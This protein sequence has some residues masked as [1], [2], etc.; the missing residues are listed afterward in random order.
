MERIK[1]NSAIPIISEVIPNVIINRF[2]YISIAGTLFDPATATVTLNGQSCEI[3][4]IT[5]TAI[6]CNASP[7]DYYGD[8]S[9]AVQ[10]RGFTSSP[11]VI[12][13]TPMPPTYD[14]IYPNYIVTSAS[15]QVTI[16]GSQF[17]IGLT[18]ATIGGLPCSSPSVLNNG[19]TIWCYSPAINTPGIQQVVI[20][21]G[22]AD[23]AQSSN[24]VTIFAP[25]TITRVNPSTVV[26]Q[27]AFFSITGTGFD[28][29]TIVNV[30][31]QAATTTKLNSTFIECNVPPTSYFGNAPLQVFTRDIG[32]N[33]ATLVMT[34]IPAVITSVY[35][36]SI[37][38][39][40]TPIVTISGSNFV[41]GSG[42][43]ITVGSL[44]CNGYNVINSTTVLCYAPLRNVVGSQ[45]IVI[46]I[47]NVNSNQFP[48]NY[49]ATAPPPLIF[50][51]LPELVSTS[52]PIITIYGQYFALSYTVM[53]NNQPC[54][55]SQSPTS[56]MIICEATQLRN[57]NFNS[58]TQLQVK[59]NGQFSNAV[60][61]RFVTNPP[62]VISIYP[63]AIQV[64]TSP[65]IT[66][67]GNQFVTGLSQVTIGGRPCPTV[68]NSGHT[69]TCQVPPS[70]ASSLPVLVINGALSSTANANTIFVNAIGLTGTGH[71]LFIGDTPCLTGNAN[72]LMMSAT[73][74]IVSNYGQLPLNIR[75]STGVTN[76][77]MVTVNYPQMQPIVSSVTP[78]VY[79]MGETT[80]VTLTGNF[81]VNPRVRVLQTS[82][83]FP[84][85]TYVS[86]SILTF[87]VPP[88]FFQNE[89]S[90]Q[91][92]VQTPTSSSNGAFFNVGSP[93]PS[94][95]S[96]N[97]QSALNNQSTLI[98]IS[99]VGFVD[100]F[101]RVTINNVQV[102]MTVASK[103]L[104]FGFVNPPNPA[105][106]GANQ[107]L[108][109]NGQRTG[110]PS[111]IVYKP[112]Q[113]NITSLS[114]S[115]KLASDTTNIVINGYGFVAGLMT[116]MVGNSQ[117]QSNTVS[118]TSIVFSARPENFVGAKQITVMHAG[119]VSNP[120][121][122]TYTGITPSID[123]ISSQSVTNIQSTQVTITGSNFMVGYISVLIQFD[124]GPVNCTILDSTN[125]SIIFDSPEVAEAGQKTVQVLNGNTVNTGSFSIL[126]Q[127]PGL[128][129]DSI[130]PPA[131]INTHSTV[132]TIH[133][134]GFDARLLTVV[135]NFNF[136]CAM[137]S[138]D[139]HYT[140]M[141]VLTSFSYTFMSPQPVV[142]S[143]Y[144]N[145]V[146]IDGSLPVTLTGSNF[147]KG[148]SSVTTGE[149]VFDS[150]PLP[151][152]GDFPCRVYNTRDNLFAQ[153]TVKYMPLPS[154][155]SITP[156]SAYA[157]SG[158]VFTIVGHGF[159]AAYSI[160][161]IM[162]PDHIEYYIAHQV[163]PAGANGLVQTYVTLPK[164]YNCWNKVTITGS[165]FMVGYVSVLIQSASGPVNC[166]IVELTST[167]IIFNSPEVAE[168]GQKTVQV[169]N[170]NTANSGS[171][172]ILYQS[173]ELVVDSIDPPAMI[174]T[175]STVITIHGSGFDARILSVVDNFNFRCAM[176]SSDVHYT[177][178]VCNLQPPPNN[179]VGTVTVT[180]KSLTDSVTSFS[181]TFMSPQPVVNSVYPNPVNIDG[182]LPV[183]LTGSN[184]QKGVTTV[185]TGGITANIIS[186]SPTEIV[187]DSTPL[188][189]IGDFPCRVYNTRDNL[190]AQITVKY[191]PLPSI[192]SI[193]PTSAN[194][195]SGTVFTIVGH[196]F[197]AAYS[198]IAIMAPDHIEY[199]IAHQVDPAGANGLVQ[200]YVTLPNTITAGTKYMAINNGPLSTQN[201]LPVEIVAPVPTIS[202]VNPSTVVNIQSTLIVIT[203]TNFDQSTTVSII[204]QVKGSVP[205]PVDTYTATTISCIAPQLEEF[206]SKQLVVAN[207]YGNVYGTINYES[208]PIVIDR[209]LPSSMPN[210]IATTITIKGSGFDTRITSFLPDPN[211]NCVVVA[212]MRDQYICTVQPPPDQ[213]EGDITVTI[214][215]L[216]PGDSA[217][218]TFTYLNSMPYLSAVQPYVANTDGSIPVTVIGSGFFDGVTTVS[219]P[220]A[221]P[222]QTIVQSITLNEIVFTI[223]TNPEISAGGHEVKVINGNNPLLAIYFYVTYLPTPQLLAVD[224]NFQYLHILVPF[225]LYGSGFLREFTTVYITDVNNPSLEQTVFGDDINPDG[226][227]SFRLSDQLMVP[228]NK[229][230]YVRNGPSFESQRLMVEVQ[231]P[232][233]SIDRIEP[234]AV[235]NQNV[236]QITLTGTNFYGPTV[237]VRISMF[238][239]YDCPVIENI[240]YD[241]LIINSPNVQNNVGTYMIEITVFDNIGRYPIEFMSSTIAVDS[242]VPSSMITTHATTITILG[243][244]FDSR[245]LSV[246]DNFNFRCPIPDSNVQFNSIVCTVQPTMYAYIGDVRVTL[247][248]STGTSATFLF[249]F[250]SPQPNITSVSPMI[251]NTAGSTLITISGSS[252]QEGISS[253]L[254]NGEIE[255]AIS[256]ITPNQI[257]FTSN[258]VPEGIQNITVTNSGDNLSATTQLLYLPS[259]VL[260][261][262]T[263]TFITNEVSSIITV[264]GTGFF[265]GH[266]VI[267]VGSPNEIPDLTFTVDNI[268]N[269]VD[270]I[271]SIP[272]LSPFFGVKDI[273]AY[274]GPS[275]SNIINLQVYKPTPV[276][277]NVDPQ[278]VDSTTATNVTLTGTN[279]VVDET[280]LSISPNNDVFIPLISIST[281]EIIFTTNVTRLIGIR[282]IFLQVEGAQLVSKDLEFLPGVPVIT[283][284][285][286]KSMNYSAQTTFTLTGYN[287]YD[288]STVSGCIVLEQN[289]TT[290]TCL[291]F[292]FFDGMILQNNTYKLRVTNNNFDSN[293]VSVQV[294]PITPV[295][296][297]ISPSVLYS[298]Q[299]IS[300]LVLTSGVMFG[301]NVTINDIQVRIFEINL[302]RVY[303]L[304]PSLPKG[305]YPLVI[306]N[307]PD[308]IAAYALTF[309]DPTPI[310]TGVSPNVTDLYATNTIITISG[311][312]FVSNFSIIT[313]G[314][315]QCQNDSTVTSTEI[316]CILSNVTTQGVLPI[317]IQNGDIISNTE[318]VEFMYPLPVNYVSPNYVIFSDQSTSTFTITLFGHGFSHY[319]DG[320]VQ[321]QKEVVGTTPTLTYQCNVTTKTDTSIECI[322]SMIPIGRYEVLFYSGHLHS[323]TTVFTVVDRALSCLSTQG[324]S[325]SWWFVR[326]IPQ[327]QSY[328][329]VDSDSQ[330]MKYLP[331]INST[332]G[333]LARTLNQIAISSS[334][335]S[336]GYVVYNDHPWFDDLSG[337]LSLSIN[338][339][340]NLNKSLGKGIFVANTFFNATYSPGF[341]IKHSMEGFPVPLPNGLFKTPS[342][343]PSSWIP[344]DYHLIQNQGDDYSLGHS[345]MC[346]SLIDSSDFVNGIQSLKPF[347][348]SSNRFTPTSTTNIF[349]SLFTDSTTN[350]FTSK[351]WSKGYFISAGFRNDIF[352][353]TRIQPL[354]ITLPS[355]FKIPSGANAITDVKLPTEFIIQNNIPTK[356]SQ[357][358]SDI[359]KSYI[360]FNDTHLCLGDYSSKTS[361]GGGIAVCVINQF[362][363][364]F[365]VES[366]FKY[367]Q[368]N[369]STPKCENQI[370]NQFFISIKS[371]LLLDNTYSSNNNDLQMILNNIDSILPNT[372]LS[373]GD[374]GCFGIFCPI[375]APYSEIKVNPTDSVGIFSFR[376]SYTPVFNLILQDTNSSITVKSNGSPISYST[377]NISGSFTAKT[378]GNIQSNNVI[379]AY[380]LIQIVKKVRDNLG[381]GT[382]G[383]IELILNGNG[384]AILNQHNDIP[385]KID[386]N[387]L[388]VQSLFRAISYDLILQLN[389]ATSSVELPELN[390]DSYL[391]FQNHQ[392]CWEE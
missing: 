350:S 39:D 3:T 72:V 17:E 74:T 294:L 63:S 80:Q 38:V 367:Q 2:P 236:T 291:T 265:V 309:I 32:S 254:I 26:N 93:L 300:L 110:S 334:E 388:D 234:A 208:P 299:Q 11:Y 391:N 329:Y 273:I 371:K 366:I 227:I 318:Y 130:D 247:R 10:S 231:W 85:V 364:E 304:T 183:T 205:C 281:T 34:P 264:T 98:Q 84:Q 83:E 239:V 282:S 58:I 317:N 5:S 360:A 295:I 182:S 28:G 108:V 71:R 53:V 8:A 194:L 351:D 82:M 44:S 115:S 170:G 314:A 45:P 16:S 344:N 347:I 246:D 238:E 252:F 189:S 293:E 223:S 203:G 262:I 268:E 62:N 154:I 91:L 370:Q 118:G 111:Q 201:P 336:N 176:L 54:P 113:P 271:I 139:V 42:S 331:S 392:H 357:W 286:P 158:T 330:D 131:M 279:F 250:S 153:I 369:C 102:Q 75:T 308:Q 13:M 29:S 23:S 184:F 50:S 315:Y 56:T 60:Q 140:Y 188:P 125:T 311:S 361:F 27:Y 70:A 202:S 245:L 4:S 192:T 40:T 187:F 297:S 316:Q 141:T 333:C 196:G 307:S 335:S 378:N 134:S 88:N 175:H 198:I 89:G 20:T 283:D 12:K 185:T 338:G 248:L 19:H 303:L 59:S 306:R 105:S 49:I 321:F 114:P 166:T 200:T 76:T 142:N 377:Y 15:V 301:A 57:T 340:G 285:Q 41:G 224:P 81:F 156:T 155:T 171:F 100:G 160:I 33:I 216:Y 87:T 30:N 257:V 95:S 260:T 195:G 103:N 217:T 73:C 36:S 37:Y 18:T 232:T 363:S 337:Q 355:K 197:V 389:S 382:L 117:V 152:I 31:N 7:S 244:G 112:S 375:T 381:L 211:F 298:H 92:I 167:K 99:G 190:F 129:I 230:I 97:P 79:I 376:G 356:I 106:L 136:R 163:D 343:H 204:S 326:K 164:Y 324:A 269:D 374:S 292:I 1:N 372:K 380:K 272:P 121:P 373:V 296:K 228:G 168:A 229:L 126:Y 235:P 386:S 278:Q 137:L 319:Q 21:N 342:S 353:P 94:I 144:P 178:M 209:V 86:P 339:Y 358:K 241:T 289:E 383:N 253:V 6:D 77:V 159:V 133:G 215:N 243:S 255:T 258:E 157:G 55:L 61:V 354:S 128:F 288:I 284:F 52:S 276:I 362:S 322:S 109:T 251:A 127:S 359:D 120:M 68:S 67:V 22:N 218:F 165:S 348:Y 14:S 143:V 384:I 172:S 69:I 214:M 210:Q 78:N 90:Y 46:R 320:K 161:A 349:S 352:T 35:P 328:I 302:N 390:F 207:E 385:I 147:Q 51:T 123:S 365:F 206:G 107:V 270:F 325:V 221:F 145:P 256:L 287:F 379:V 101:T 280:Q 181:Y 179:F 135:D 124:S 47:G 263:P 267:A 346:H 213:L 310:I 249:T 275:S 313:V 266:T 233:P 25:P 151:S 323:N 199:Y 240:N 119:L 64:N 173:P 65:Y 169:L 96:I 180:L 212:I 116:V 259:P 220:D 327:S 341:H 174:N 24:V 149:I 48:L 219:I 138:S 261:F 43:Q 332:T 237:Q 148:V 290:I 177:Y 9:V 191:M 277:T 186:I 222:V 162:A 226:S 146:N 132:I 312:G 225:T 193:N 368:Q 274:N 150:T 305:T 242:V 345:F 66:I 122:L 104:M 387:T